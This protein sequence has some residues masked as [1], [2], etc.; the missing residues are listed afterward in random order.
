MAVAEHQS[1]LRGADRHWRDV[2][3]FFGALPMPVS[4][5]LTGADLSDGAPR[6]RAAATLD[7][8]SEVP[9]SGLGWLASS[10]G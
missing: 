6:E 8:A 9:S 3:T 10:N 4:S 1:D 2:L 5:Y 7:E